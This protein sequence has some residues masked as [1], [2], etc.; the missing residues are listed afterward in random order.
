M[1]DVWF[2]I[3]SANAPLCGRT[4]GLWKARG[5]RTAVLIDGDTPIPDN[6][7]HVIRT[8][9]YHGWSWA[10]NQLCRTL[11]CDFMV[12]GGDDHEPADACPSA[13]AAQ[14]TLR[15]GGTYGVMQPTGD[16]YGR[17][18]EV[19]PSPWIGRA[20]A[21]KFGPLHEGY[22]GFFSDEELACVA[23]REK[24]LWRRP[25][26]SQ[27]HRHFAREDAP[28]ADY[29]RTARKHWKADRDLFQIRKAAGFPV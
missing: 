1:S 18:D 26:L 25:D 23:E 5:Y 20:F 29:Q 22:V 17:I 15:F 13:V 2:A 19:C 6:A 21:R 12:T 3:P 28:M 8:P 10:V 4:F 7:D 24:V 27:Y 9:D 16:R 11:D 14:C